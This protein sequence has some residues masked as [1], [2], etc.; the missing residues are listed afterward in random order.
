MGDPETAKAAVEGAASLPWSW[1]EIWIGI[2]TVVTTLATWLTGRAA[3]TV[4]TVEKHAELVPTLA[5]RI[6]ALESKNTLYET[7]DDASRSYDHLRNDIATLRTDISDKF[8]LVAGL[9]RGTQK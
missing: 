3:K 7:K 1:H 4:G 8:N 6:E 2:G 5:T 9:I